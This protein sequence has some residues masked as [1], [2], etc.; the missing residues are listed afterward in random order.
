MIM[1]RFDIDSL[2]AFELLR[3]LS[4]DSNT[5]IAEIARQLVET[6]HPSRDG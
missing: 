4:Q 1:E 2:Q 3:K 6:D 5:P